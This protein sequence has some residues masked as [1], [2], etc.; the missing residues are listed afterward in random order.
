[1]P[2]GSAAAA[3]GRGAETRS[4]RAQKARAGPGRR[5][6]KRERTWDMGADLLGR[7]PGRTCSGAVP[8]QR[9]TRTCP[10]WQPAAPI[11]TLPVWQATAKPALEQ[12]EKI[13][14]FPRSQEGWRVR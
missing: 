8:F 13:A 10:E 4:A 6:R 9:G 14:I 1:M 5:M 7:V 2:A 3:G 12:R 11:Y